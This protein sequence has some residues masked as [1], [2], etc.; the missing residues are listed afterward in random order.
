M[1]VDCFIVMLQHALM[2]RLHALRLQFSVSICMLVSA[3]KCN[4]N[5]VFRFW[6]LADGNLT[7]EAVE[8]MC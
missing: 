6:K 1:T 4:L 2:L 7:K 8:L 5:D 3:V